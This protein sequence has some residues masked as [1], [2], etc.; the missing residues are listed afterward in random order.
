MDSRAAREELR[1]YGVIWVV[2][3]PI[4]WLMAAISTVKSDAV[5]NV[6]LA[7]FS[8]A[9][10]CALLLG[11]GAVFRKS[12]GRL[13]LVILSWLAS[14]LFIGPGLTIL[15]GGFSAQNVDFAFVGLGVACFGLL[16]VAMALRLHKLRLA[17]ATNDA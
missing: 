12:W 16:F 2:L 3:A 10:I 13:G 15:G 7:V 5:Y 17:F 1:A 11:F 14:L 8:L 6:Q 9:A 4:A